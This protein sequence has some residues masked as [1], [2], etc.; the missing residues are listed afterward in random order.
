MYFLLFKNL[1][2]FVVLSFFSLKCFATPTCN[3]TYESTAEFGGKGPK[4]FTVKNLKPGEMNKIAGKDRG[5]RIQFF[6][7]RLQVSLVD[8]NDSNLGGTEVYG[9]KEKAPI[10]VSLNVP[11]KEE[12]ENLTI[13]CVL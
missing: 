6:K 8:A 4:V 9:L 2:R 11:V 5:A 12:S 10:K 3:A 7:D 1:T 13:D